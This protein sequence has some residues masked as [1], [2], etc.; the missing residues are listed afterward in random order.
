MP[1][2]IVTPYIER[3]PELAELPPEDVSTR[4][5]LNTG[6]D[7]DEK[8]FLGAAAQW[9]G[10]A[11]RYPVGDWRQDG[12]GAWVGMRFDG[13]GPIVLLSGK[14]GRLASP[15]C[16]PDAGAAVEGFALPGGG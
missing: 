10:D 3:M 16:H 8:P 14:G 11:A 5:L 2:A 7:E 12:L 13:L 6:D 1:D 9:F 4:R 15:G